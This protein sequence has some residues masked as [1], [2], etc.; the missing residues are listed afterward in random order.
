MKK[1]YI[2]IKTLVL[3]AL[4]ISFIPVKTYAYDDILAEQL[5]NID[6]TKINHLVEQ[7]N[8]EYKEY[9]PKYEIRDFVNM[10]NKKRF[11]F[12]G[13]LC[14]VSKYMFREVFENYHL[15]GTL[16][17]LAILCT[18]LRNMQSNFENT[19]IGK[20]TYSV[21]YLVLI[22]I[23]VR[24]FSLALKVG[25]EA[26]DKM[27]SFIQ[28]LMPV[29][30]T[31]LTSIGGI[32]SMAIFNPLIFTSI[33]IAS[34]WIKNILL[35]II[36][37]ASVLGVVSNIPTRFNVSFLAS[38]LKQICVF[39]LG[40]F[41]SIFLGVLVVNGAASATV[42]GISI[43]TAKFA[44]KNFIP[45]IGG[46]FSDTVDT[47]VGCSL[48]LKNAVGVFGLFIVLLMTIFPVIKILSLVFIY[49]LSG[50]LI[51]PIGEDFIVKCLND[52]ANSLTLI[53]VA[54]ASV[55]VMFFVA[56]TVILSAGNITVMLR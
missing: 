35:P 14:G 21:V 49:K 30:L 6:D 8:E 19:N 23:A 28:A 12:K 51:Q 31:L 54:V 55:A 5:N 20:V 4:L 9:I 11:D 53:F 3:I 16:I 17:A 56:I 33:T 52:M 50:V 32:T 42:D 27:V 15:M 34:T 41:M 44:S 39:L 43:R 29:I 7:L 40:L 1:F 48:I 18:I 2:K 25:E 24:S 37:F 13:F 47:I 36:F 38:F 45:I 22:S 46:I 26:I 10:K